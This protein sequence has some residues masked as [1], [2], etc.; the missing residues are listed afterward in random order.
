MTAKRRSILIGMIAGALWAPAVV[1]APAL[2]GLPYLPAPVTLPGAFLAPGL[3][4]ALVIGRI[5]ARRFFDDALID[6]AEAALGSAA[7]IDQ[8]VLRNTAEQLVL[9]LAIW[10]FAALTL[11]G[12]VAIALGLSFAAMRLLFW[13]GYRWSPPLRA[14]GFAATFYPTVLAGVWALLF[15]AV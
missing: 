2:M 11:G 8:R 7:E 14:F 9:A 6:G 4:L 13:I 12:A 5:A 10:P 1:F 15:W 3:V